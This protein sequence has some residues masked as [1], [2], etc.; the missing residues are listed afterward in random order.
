MCGIGGLLL[1][2]KSLEPQ[3][4]ALTASMLGALCDRGPD[5]AGFAVYGAEQPGT[6][7]LTLRVPDGFDTQALTGDKRV[8]DTHVV[9]TVPVADEAA[10]R[11]AIAEG[12][13]EVA[14]VGSGRRMEVY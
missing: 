4:G 5:S 8:R 13:P 12:A 9:L 3:L 14:I 11:K 7:K 1:K 10:V 6:V 2:D